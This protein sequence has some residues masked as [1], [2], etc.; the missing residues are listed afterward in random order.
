MVVCK[1]ISTNIHAVGPHRNTRYDLPCVQDPHVFYSFA[2]A[3]IPISKNVPRSLAKL[4]D[5]DGNRLL[6]G[7]YERH[8]LFN[9]VGSIYSAIRIYEKMLREKNTLKVR[10]IIAR[11]RAQ[12]KHLLPLYAHL[13]QVDIQRQ[14]IRIEGR[15][16]RVTSEM[17]RISQAGLF[18]IGEALLSMPVEIRQALLR[19][20]YG[21]PALRFHVMKD[22]GRLKRRLRGS[23]A[24]FHGRSR[25]I[26]IDGRHL[27]RARY[28]RFLMTLKHEHGHAVDQLLGM[29][30]AVA[31]CGIYSMKLSRSG[32]RIHWNMFKCSLSFLQRIYFHRSRWPDFSRNWMSRL[33]KTGFATQTSIA[34]FFYAFR[35]NSRRM[36]YQRTRRLTNIHRLFIS[37]Y[38][39]T[40]RSES[41]AEM[42][43]AYWTLPSPWYVKRVTRVGVKRR[44]PLHYEF[45]NNLWNNPTFFGK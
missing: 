38:G 3:G 1:S 33:R 30:Q 23:S 4:F 19:P 40:D 35:R 37:A 10:T 9:Q 2:Q 29:K 15:T 24:V 27:R 42:W 28:P 17:G 25:R 36:R 31:R 20:L 44:S 21:L 6:R 11:L 13:P 16:I 26:I 22:V 34:Q 39:A 32:V 7:N 5:P 41:F 14:T 43:R 12:L 45:F 8:L 18:A